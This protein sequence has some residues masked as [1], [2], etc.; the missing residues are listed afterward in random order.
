V[1]AAGVSCQNSTRT[2]GT[3]QQ[4]IPLADMPAYIQDVLDLIEWANG[5]T[6]STWGAVRAAAGHPASFGLKYLGVGNEDKITSGFKERFQMI[7]EAVQ[8]KHPEITVIGT[9]GPAPDGE[10]FNNGWQFATELHI[11]IVDEHYY[12][13]PQWFWDN[14][15]R[16]DKYDRAKSKVYVGEYAAHDGKRR[17]T[18]R[19]AL[20]EAAYLTSM[21]KNGDVVQFASYAPLLARRGHTQW[22]PDMIY[23]N[24]TEVFPTISYYVQQLFGLNGGDTYLST[25]AS[26][27]KE[28]AASSVRDSATG[29]LIVKLVNGAS[30][31][32][33]LR[34]ELN[35]VATFPRSATKTVLTGANANVVNPEGG[36]PEAKPEVSSIE[37]GQ[38]FDY[39]APANSFTVIRLKP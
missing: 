31:P 36:V 8:K 35:G 27:S 30:V 7:Y 26:D 11:P 17:S 39:E 24:G 19:A 18:L 13:S 38:A 37:V 6:N 12:K 21:E 10:D 32:K 23:F 15:Q 14:L 5:P 34:I 22:T 29:D 3:G 20:A 9:V 28:F 1:L 4:C 16:Y 25:M 2:R 33:L